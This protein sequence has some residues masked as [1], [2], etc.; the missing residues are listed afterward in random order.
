MKQK[1]NTRKILV[2]II[3]ATR[4]FLVDRDWMEKIKVRVKTDDV[5]IKRTNLS[6]FVNNEHSNTLLEHFFTA[7]RDKQ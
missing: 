4:C 1:K 5:R 7:K 2:F 3:I 6:V